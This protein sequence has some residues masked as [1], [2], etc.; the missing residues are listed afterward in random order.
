[1]YR[2]EWLSTAEH[3]NHQLLTEELLDHQDYLAVKRIRDNDLKPRHEQKPLRELEPYIDPLSQLFKMLQR[4][5]TTGEKYGGSWNIFPFLF[6]LWEKRNFTE[7]IREG[8]CWEPYPAEGGEGGGL[9]VIYSQCL[10]SFMTLVQNA[11][12]IL[13]KHSPSNVD[14]LLLTFLFDA[15]GIC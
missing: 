3:S 10:Q 13:C 4:L 5:A 15:S 2:R 1:M 14:T 11:P 12:M 7:E 6:P 9:P 8:V